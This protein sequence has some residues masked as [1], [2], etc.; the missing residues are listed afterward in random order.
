MSELGLFPLGLVLLPTEQIPLHIFEDRYQELIGECLADDRDFGLIYADEDGLRDLGTRAAVTEVL[1]RFEDGRL[2][3]VVEGRERFRLVELTEGRSFQ[4][5]VVEPVVDEPD[6]AD[7]ADEERA[8]E[9]FRRL[10]ELTGADVGAPESDAAPLS[11]ALAGRFE[12]AAELKQR[13]LALRSERERVTMLIE[14]LEGAAIA[15]EREQE[16]AGRAA[17]NGK[18]DPRG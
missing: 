2:N 1:E 8:L 14:V 6:P 7:P 10:V 4:T 15:V 12:F 16:I 13:L 17:S 9:L 11:F 5:G 18:V 3:I